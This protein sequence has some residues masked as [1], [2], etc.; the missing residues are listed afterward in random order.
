MNWGSDT[1]FWKLMDLHVLEIYLLSVPFTSILIH[2]H[3]IHDYGPLASICMELGGADIQNEVQRLRDL[4]RW[5]FERRACHVNL[6][7]A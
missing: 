7:L 6:V 3:V 4:N 2:D 1:I 5:F